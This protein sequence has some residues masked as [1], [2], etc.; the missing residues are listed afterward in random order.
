MSPLPVIKDVLH[1]LIRRDEAD[2]PA[3]RPSDPNGLVLEAWGKSGYI[4]DCFTINTLE[5]DN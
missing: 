4:G 2:N 5:L 3:D 1:T